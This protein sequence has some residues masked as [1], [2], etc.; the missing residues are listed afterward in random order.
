MNLIASIDKLALT[1]YALLSLSFL[2]SPSPLP[3]TAHTVTL[4]AMASKE[5]RRPRSSRQLRNYRFEVKKV[6]KGHL[7]PSSLSAHN[8]RSLRAVVLDFNKDQTT[9]ST[10][11]LLASDTKYILNGRMINDVFYITGPQSIHQ[12]SKQLETHIQSC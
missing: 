1:F 7:V 2:P 9:T 10:T 5:L 12:Y 3:H 8:K 11:H 4:V 6:L